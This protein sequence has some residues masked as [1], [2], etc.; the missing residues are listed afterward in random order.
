MKKLNKMLSMLLAVIM[1]LGMSITA[2]ADDGYTITIEG[3]QKGHTY[4]AYQVFS[5][6]L[7]EKG[8]LTE[9]AWGNGVSTTGQT[10]LGYATTAASELTEANVDDFA[11]KVAPYAATVAGSVAATGD[12]AQITGLAAGYYLIKDTTELSDK[13]AA[14]TSYILYVAGNVTV[15]TKTDV[16]TLVKKVADD[17]TDVTTLTNDSTDW[18]DSADYSEG[19]TVPFKLTATLPNNVSDYTKYTLKFNDTLSEGLTFNEDSVA[20]TVVDKNSA[21]YTLSSNGDYVVNHDGTTLTFT[22]SDLKTIESLKVATLDEAQVI[23]RYTATL[24]ENAVIGYV[25]NPNTANLEYSNNPNYTG[26]GSNS[27]DGTPEDTTPGGKDD[28][29]T[30]KTPDDKVIVFTYELDITKID[31]AATVANTELAGVTFALYTKA[32][33]EKGESGTPIDTITNNNDGK[34]AFE[35][36]DAGEYVLVEAN[37]PDGYNKIDPIS[38]KIEATH[39]DG[40]EPALTSLT[41][42]NSDFVVGTSD[43][44]YTGKITTKITNNKGASL[45]STGGMGTRVIYLIGGALVLAASVL[46]VTKRRMSNSK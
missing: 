23:V 13:D 38:F 15:D 33:Y 22:I 12:N 26:T 32:E 42:D 14:Y 24:N 2:M 6:S 34:F 20:I 7:S 29:S 31:G 5:G 30:G 46:L 37:A 9:I 1:V 39:T 27:S 10:A 17:I 18:K 8:E 41:V 45:P 19:D 44:K 28:D 11:K 40:D 25:G 43:S 36:I 16:P 35:R 21:E 3:S 4:S